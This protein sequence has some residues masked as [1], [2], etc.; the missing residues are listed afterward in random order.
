MLISSATISRFHYEGGISGDRNPDLSN[1]E[2]DGSPDIKSETSPVKTVLGILE[3]PTVMLLDP[4]PSMLLLG[5][6]DD[7]GS[8]FRRRYM[9]T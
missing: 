3:L 8:I 4:Y 1:A 9:G 2:N 5:P 7:S 6:D